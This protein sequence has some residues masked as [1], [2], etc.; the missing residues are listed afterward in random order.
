M[1]YYAHNISLSLLI[2]NILLSP[3]YNIKENNLLQ[4]NI[5]VN[6]LVFTLTSY[7]LFRKTHLN[8]I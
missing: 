2:C 5:L 8:Y 4:T 1:I 6:V 7:P 3:I